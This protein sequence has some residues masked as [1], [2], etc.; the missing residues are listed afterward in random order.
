MFMFKD[1]EEEDAEYHSQSVAPSSKNSVLVSV[2][3]FAKVLIKTFFES[4]IVNI[5]LPISY[6][7]CVGCSKEQ[8][9]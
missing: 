5:F 3:T 7:I 2:C 4:K 6:N 8:H 1:E 9:S